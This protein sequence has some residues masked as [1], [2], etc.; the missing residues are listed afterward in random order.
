METVEIEQRMDNAID[1]IPLKE[2]LQ[3]SKDTLKV[4]M[5]RFEKYRV[6]PYNSINRRIKAASL[7]KAKKNIALS[8]IHKIFGY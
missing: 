7:R 6:N 4:K 5:E 3:K 1:N 8:I 2:E